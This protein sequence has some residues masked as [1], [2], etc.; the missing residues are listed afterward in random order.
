MKLGDFYFVKNR[1]GA[2]NKKVIGFNPLSECVSVCERVLDGG[3][4]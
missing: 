4:L 1:I 2:A 3:I